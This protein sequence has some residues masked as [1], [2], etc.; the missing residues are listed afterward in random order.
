MGKAYVKKRIRRLKELAD[1]ETD[2]ESRELL[3]IFHDVFKFLVERASPRGTE[4]DEPDEG[5]EK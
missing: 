4:L 3:M 1:K 5:I 2:H